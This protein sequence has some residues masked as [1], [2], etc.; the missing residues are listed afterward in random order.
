MT[1]LTRRSV[2]AG[3]LGVAASGVLAGPRFASAAPSGPDR[4]AARPIHRWA[5]DTWASLVAMTDETT[6]LTADNIEASIRN[7]VRSGYTSPTNI[8]GY[9]WSAIVARELDLISARE[10]RGRIRQTLRTLGRIERHEPSGQYYNWYDETDGSKLTVWPTDGNTVYPFMSSVDNGWLAAAL[11]VVR[12]ADPSNAERADKLLR[13]MNFKVYYNPKPREDAQTGL[14]KGGFW[15]GTVPPDQTPVV[16]NYLGD[17]SPD[18]NYTGFHYD[19]TVSET[20]IASYIA[21]ARGQVPPQHYF[22]TYRAFPPELDFQERRPTGQTRT[23][24]GID[25]YE[26]AYEYRGMRLACGWGGSMFEALMPNMFVPEE[27]W[28]PRSWGVNHPLTVRA[29][30]EHGLNEA[31]YGYW[32]FSPASDPT[33]DPGYREYGVDAIGMNPDGYFSDVERSNYDA[34]DYGA[35]PGTSPRPAYGDG[36]VT[37]HALFL[38]MHHEPQNAYANLRKLQREHRSYGQG[39]FFDAVAVGSGR[40]ARRYLSLDQ[41]MVLGSI[42][43]VIGNGIVRKAF[44]AGEIRRRIK[45]LIAME[46]FGSSRG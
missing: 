14:L 4:F 44:C 36:V 7:P 22:G 25:V 13:R 24:L 31:R 26:G 38:A 35:R 29:Q 45:P 32:G 37:P 1:A 46:R 9:L 5:A 43:N 20:R 18:V 8:G 21:I 6:G 41:S 12:N 16:D 2:L 27:R 34:G 10:C 3:G 28:A 19:T 39:G 15:D 40:V 30:R 42:G 17:G 11:I 23:Y 33:L